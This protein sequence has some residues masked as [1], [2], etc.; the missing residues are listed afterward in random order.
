MKNCSVI[1]MQ[2]I[3]MFGYNFFP[4]NSSTALDII[5]IYFKLTIHN[6]LRTLIASKQNFINEKSLTNI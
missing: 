6:I 5:N 2:A 1:K 4:I 3:N